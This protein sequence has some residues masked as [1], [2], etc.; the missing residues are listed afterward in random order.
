MRP[1]ECLGRA[2]L[3]QKERLASGIRSKRLGPWL[4]AGALVLLFVLLRWNNYNAPL[5]RDEG[6]YAYAA[7]LLRHGLT[8]Y[9]DCFLQKPP[10]VVY[11]YLL[12]SLAAPGVFWF[13]RILAGLFIAAATVVLG[14]IARREF[15]S[16][17]A[18]TAMALF[19]PMVLLPEL[20]QF[21]ANTEMF[22][23]LP[24]LGALAVYS[25]YRANGDD[26][27][28]WFFSGLLGSIAFWYK[29]TCL[30]LLVLLFAY[31]SWETLRR[32]RAAGANPPTTTPQGMGL[33]AVRTGWA[34]LG[35]RWLALALGA[36][37]SSLAVL[38][39]FL[40]RDGGRHFW[41]CTIEF[42][43]FYAHSIN[44]APDL[45]ANRLEWF[46][47]HWWL[48][49]LVLPA[50]VLEWTPRLRFWL[51]MFLVSWLTT[52]GSG[53][54]QYYLLVMPFWALLSAVALRGLAQKVAARFSSPGSGLR[55]VFALVTVLF[56]CW[57]DLHFVALSN[58]AFAR[59]KL[60][61]S[62][63]FLE[64]P[65]VAR[66]VSALTAPGD[67]VL[68]AGSEPQI[69]VYAQR[70]SPTRFV[71]TAPLMI[72]SPLAEGFQQEAIQAL[73]ARPPAL[74][75]LARS[76][77]SWLM[78]ENSPRDYPQFLYQ[79]LNEKYHPVGGYVLDETSGRWEEPLPQ[80]ALTNASLILFQPGPQH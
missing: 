35:S 42:N 74:I 40:L 22:L 68:V 14:A 73:R 1:V 61:G 20:E 21:H 2:G 50:L 71:I 5:I 65:L 24:L 33:S 58:K 27:R 49:F 39:L 47:T 8:P 25:Y 28:G 43:R 3:P 55:F 4:C 48:L 46:W 69:L 31:W 44:F 32:R 41:E 56:V 63:P 11:T 10:M 12:S 30:P 34:T 18:W 78:E 59:E 19:T 23:L 60:A 66:R 9:Q 36:L 79:M 64:S 72:P 77:T 75:V 17:T 76:N 26:V 52:N 37:A 57:P 53:Y 80:T 7:Q 70:F 16:A 51:A 67:Y 38:G 54:G 45:F 13:P 29:Y 6:E 62:N 15:D